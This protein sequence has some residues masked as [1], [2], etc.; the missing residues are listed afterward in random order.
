MRIKGLPL[1]IKVIASLVECPKTVLQVSYQCQASCLMVNEAIARLEKAGVVKP[2]GSLN[3]SRA[4]FHT[5][6]VYQF[7]DNWAG[8]GG[9]SLSEVNALAAVASSPKPVS[10]IE[11]PE[12]AGQPISVA[13]KSIYRLYRMNLL[14]RQMKPKHERTKGEKYQYVYD[15][16]GWQEIIKVMPTGSFNPGFR[17]GA[18]SRIRRSKPSTTEKLHPIVEALHG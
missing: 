6:V 16:R 3:G 11:I 2:A 8:V 5:H 13:Y 14:K 4:S 15:P 1:D 9:T 12:K 10:I 18:G 7:V 17:S